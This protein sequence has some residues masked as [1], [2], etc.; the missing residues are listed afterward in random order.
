[1]L[2]LVALC[3]SQA[4]HGGASGRSLE[5][6]SL[7]ASETEG[8]AWLNE[9]F[10]SGEVKQGW[11]SLPNFPWKRSYSEKCQV[12]NFNGETPNLVDRKLDRAEVSFWK[13]R[14]IRVAIRYKD[15]GGKDYRKRI[16]GQAALDK[17]LRTAR[18]K[19]GRK[20]SDRETWRHL[21]LS[22]YELVYRRRSGITALTVE[23]YDDTT[24]YL[25]GVAMIDGR[26]GREVEKCDQAELA[27]KTR[28]ETDAVDSVLP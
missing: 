26:L 1:M 10:D 9:R 25:S 18:R 21:R 27:R 23:S 17:F 6:L 3:G 28:E 11:T 22:R 14:V 20:V 12:K 15:L 4:A 2:A 8:L 5:G 13:G 24:Y 7:R 19:Y 16:G